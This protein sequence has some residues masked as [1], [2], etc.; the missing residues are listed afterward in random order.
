MEAL[1]HE[2]KKIGSLS[3][4]FFIGYGYILIL[5]KLFLKEFSVDVSIFTKVVIYALVS[6]KSVAIMDMTPWMNRF[7]E[8]PRYLQVLYK[9][10]VYTFAVF[11][12]SLIENLF[13]AYHETKALIPALTL[14]LKTRSFDRF[15]AILL[16]VSAVFLIHNIFQELDQYL[17]KGNLSKFFFKPPQ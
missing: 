14:F 16:C 10:A 13:H 3:L 12:L 17:G 5:M 15:L 9:T 8:S 11:V 2:L 7:A 4:F 1:K 6:A